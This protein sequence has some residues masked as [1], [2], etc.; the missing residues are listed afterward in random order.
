[1]R[2]RRH[3]T[4]AEVGRRDPRTS[5][6]FG[7]ERC[8]LLRRERRSELAYA[9]RGALR[10]RRRRRHRQCANREK[11]DKHSSPHDRPPLTVSC[12]LR[13]VSTVEGGVKPT[14]SASPEACGYRRYIA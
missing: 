8:A 5:A 7:T 13:I 3:D 6:D 11:G 14:D 12:L 4:S 2:E 9:G 10:A 1:M